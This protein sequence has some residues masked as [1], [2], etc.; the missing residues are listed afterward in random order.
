SSQSRL[1]GDIDGDIEGYIE[2]DI[3]EESVR[4][5]KFLEKSR[6]LHRYR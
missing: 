6:S 4:N 1:E 2:E 5:T 3:E